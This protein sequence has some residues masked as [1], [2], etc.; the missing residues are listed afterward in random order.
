MPS[1][2][3]PYRSGTDP[4]LR[5]LSPSVV[6]VI[7]KILQSVVVV[8][9]QKERK[10][11]FQIGQ[12]VRSKTCRWPDMVIRNGAIDM[13]NFWVMVLHAVNSKQERCAWRMQGH[14][15]IAH[16]SDNESKW[17]KDGKQVRSKHLSS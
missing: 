3:P 13:L 11:R 17:W 12:I 9:S 10:T 1:L 15:S 14:S 2:S 4:R 8:M 7:V 6:L 5:R 16:F